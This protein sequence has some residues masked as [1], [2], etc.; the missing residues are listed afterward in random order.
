[1]I[2]LRHFVLF[3]VVFV[4]GVIAWDNSHAQTVAPAQPSCKVGL[5]GK[6]AP[7]MPRYVK[8]NSGEH[9]FYWC[10]RPDGWT[11]TEGFSCPFTVGEC[12]IGAFSSRM[13]GIMAA[14]DR[15]AAASAAWASA[16]TY[17]CDAAIRA[18]A[19][20]RGRMCAER[21]AI[22]AANY[23]TW[24]A[25]L[26]QPAPPAPPASAPPAGPSTW[27]TPAAGTFTLYTAAGGK[28][29]ATVPGRKAPANTLCNCTANKVV[30]LSATYC[31]IDGGAAAEVTLCRE[32]K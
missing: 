6:I 27:R 21:Q 26:V 23:A 1:M 16:F 30:G 25:G 22:L 14:P 20:D 24:T 15:V 10:V 18:E 12:G 31:A 13:A 7:Y 28:L 19:S 17:S 29:L 2:R 32:V 5:D 3:A 4:L 11:V 8:G 9:V